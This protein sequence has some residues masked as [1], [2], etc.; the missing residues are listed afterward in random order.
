MDGITGIVGVGAILLLAG[1]AL[2]LMRQRVSARWLLAAVA[3]V[4]VNDVM[5][6]RGY[7]LM[8][9]LF[10]QGDWNWQGKILA[11]AATLLIASL[12]AFGW[13]ESRLTLA[14]AAGSLK[15]CIPVAL[16]YI[17]FFAVIAWAFPSEPATAETLAFQLTMPGLEEEP[18]Y[19]GILLL[20]LDRAF[21]GHRKFLGVEWGW[22]SALSC[23]AFGLAHAFGFSD[24][25]FSFDPLTMLLTAVP[26]LI[27]VWLALRTRSV[28]LPVVLHNFGNAV[29]LLL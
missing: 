12:P 17:A 21:L 26:S 13:R 15:A 18:F 5:L 8:P 28:L 25:Q 9:D 10:P 23:M 3:L 4:V 6:T 29:T 19:R 16:L 14:Q 22:G 2:R 11:L 7:G 27:G 1:G 20:A 24:G